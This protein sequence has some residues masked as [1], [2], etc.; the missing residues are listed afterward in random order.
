M[1]PVEPVT[2]TV[3]A[4]Q[5]V[6]PE[7]ADLPLVEMSGTLLF[8]LLT[9]EIAVQRQQ[10]DLAATLYL[11]VAQEVRDPR[12]AEQAAR[13]ALFSQRDQE[14]LEASRLWLE[15]APDSQAAR[16]AIVSAYIRNGD[17]QAVQEHL[18][19]LLINNSGDTEQAYQ[20]IVSLLQHGRNTQMAFRVMRQLVERHADSAD[21]QFALS[22]VALHAQQ[23]DV[24]RTA[25]EKSLS[26]HPRQ[27]KAMNLYSRVI[28]LQGNPFEAAVYL[29]G[30]VKAFPDAI[31]VRLN[32]ARLLVDNRQLDEAL[33]QYLWL[34]EKEPYDE[35]VLFVT[36]LLSLQL[37]ALDQSRVMLQRLV[38]MGRRLDVAH[39]YLGQIADMR[40][41]DDIAIDHYTEVSKGEHYLDAQLRMIVLLARRGDLLLARSY[42]SKIRE[43]MPTQMNRIDLVEGQI[44]AQDGQFNEA[45]A[46]YQSALLRDAN[47]LGLLYGRA[48]LAEKLGQYDLVEM[49]LLHILEIEPDNVSALNALGFSLADRST[50]YQE[51]YGYLQRAV[52]LRPHSP[53]ILDSMGWV[54]YR[55]GRLDESLDYLRRS[56]EI[57][58]DQE[59]AA[60]LGEVLWMRGEHDEARSVWHQALERAPDDKLILEVMKRF[61]Q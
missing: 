6:P 2:I 14:A 24:A 43:Q 38:D 49:D 30:V 9:A 47:D 28:Q 26:L 32:F 50:R 8:R 17:E 31:P 56:L 7:Q 42:V 36:A 23:L 10:F 20:L 39:F 46:I 1:S 40:N 4:E 60:H 53:A 11:A 16:E 44:L 19:Y 48:L 15:L 29:A 22:Y 33:E 55:L 59:V 12:V 58:P 34:T 35:D 51:A 52:E 61:G 57:N 54:L 27:L 21:A 25:I 37:S 18:E 13:M 45:M 3:K 5:V 41:E